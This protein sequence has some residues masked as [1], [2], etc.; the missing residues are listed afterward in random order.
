MLGRGLLA[1]ADGRGS[2]RIDRRSDPS[3][4]GI[5]IF[6]DSS[7]LRP[8]VNMSCDFIG[9]LADNSKDS[10][11]YSICG[12]AKDIG[13]ILK[14]LTTRLYACNSSADG[15]SLS[16]I[17]VHCEVSAASQRLSKASG[18]VSPV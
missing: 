9:V 12:R 1:L 3:V 8:S 18:I 13:P 17:T 14:G 7:S 11:E 6:P 5:T 16:T 10:A 15:E 4:D 2:V